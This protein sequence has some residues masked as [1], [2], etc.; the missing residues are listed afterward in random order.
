MMLPKP[1]PTTEIDVIAADI[2]VIKSY[3]C[4]KNIVDIKKIPTINKIIMTI[5]EFIISSLIS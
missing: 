5:T 2:L 3:P 4:K 1:G